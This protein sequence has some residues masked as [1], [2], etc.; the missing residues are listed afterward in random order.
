MKVSEIKEMGADQMKEKL[1]DLKKQL[2]NL[3]FQ[4]TVGQLEN[5]ATLS[6][7][8][9]DIARLYTV[10]KEMNVNIS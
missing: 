5:T 10:S 8:K 6:L 4:N 7:V 9:K 1:M 2:F 3:R